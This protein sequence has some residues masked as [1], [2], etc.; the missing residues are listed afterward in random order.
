[1]QCKQ[2]PYVWQNVRFTSV[3]DTEKKKI[4][5]NHNHT[6]IA[7]TKYGDKREGCWEWMRV[8]GHSNLFYTKNVKKKPHVCYD[9]EIESQNVFTLIIFTNIFYTFF[10]MVCMNTSIYAINGCSHS[11]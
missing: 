10:S 1:M 4:Y 11:H 3:K 7:A 9:E 6:E 2:A 5:V 8:D